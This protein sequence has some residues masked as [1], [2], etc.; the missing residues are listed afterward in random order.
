MKTHDLDLGLFVLTL[1]QNWSEL[2]ADTCDLESPLTIANAD[3]GVGALQISVAKFLG[4]R[5]PQ[6]SIACLEELLD[7]FAATRELFN[8]FDQQ[9]LSND[10]MLLIGRSFQ[11]EGD[12]IRVWY[13]SNGKD[14]VLVTY[15]CK[16]AVKA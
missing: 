16:W 2:E 12:F 14:I 5:M 10:N 7:D 8:S 11:N 9:T 1:P 4:G 13:V 6:V 3:T 15:V